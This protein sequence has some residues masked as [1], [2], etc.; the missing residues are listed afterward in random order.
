M[1]L[2]SVISNMA[3]DPSNLVCVLNSEKSGMLIYV[4]LILIG[5][6]SF[7]GVYVYKKD[8]F[9]AMTMT[10][11]SLFVVSIPLVIYSCPGDNLLSVKFVIMFLVGTASFIAL[12]KATKRGE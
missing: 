12:T 8:F 1:G 4:F 5:I 11:F 9:I 3:G 7:I 6:F 10:F 2:T